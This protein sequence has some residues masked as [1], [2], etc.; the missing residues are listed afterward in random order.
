MYGVTVIR[1][2]KSRMM[3]REGHVVRLGEK[4]NRKGWSCLDNI[5][6]D[7]GETEYG[8]VDRIGLAQVRNK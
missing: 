6:M 7:L 8:D 2:I 1:I 5:K 3:R 4:K